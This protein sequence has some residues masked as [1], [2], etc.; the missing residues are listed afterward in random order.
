MGV[1]LAEQDI[2]GNQNLWPELEGIVTFL[3]VRLGHPLK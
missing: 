3:L 1:E 2:G